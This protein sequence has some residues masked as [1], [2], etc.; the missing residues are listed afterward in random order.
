MGGAAGGEGF[1]SLSIAIC[2][3]AGHLRDLIFALALLLSGIS[4]G[5]VCTMAGQM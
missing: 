2:K 1:K 5:I 4:A 3:L